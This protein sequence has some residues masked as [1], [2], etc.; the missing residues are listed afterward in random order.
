[1]I[2]GCAMHTFA[3][4]GVAQAAAAAA[5]EAARLTAALA[6][7]EAAG[8]A[9]E[10]GRADAAEREARAAAAL[11]AARVRPACYLHISILAHRSIHLSAAY[12]SIVYILAGRDNRLISSSRP[13]PWFIPGISC[14]GAVAGGSGGGGGAAA[15]AAGGCPIGER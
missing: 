7:A 10:A 6:A 12:L 1:M 8:A 5:G 4:R 15:G 14:R 13:H 9:A 11:D 2:S 3:L